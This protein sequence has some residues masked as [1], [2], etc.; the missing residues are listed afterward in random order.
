MQKITKASFRDC[1]ISD[2]K[3]FHNSKCLMPI[4]IGQKVHEGDKFLSTI[5]LIN[6]SF[7]SCVILIDDSV[8]RH[9]IKI[10][11]CSDEDTLYNKAIYEG[12]LWLE[13][14]QKIYT[15]LTIPY[16]IIRWDKFLRHPEFRNK[17][18]II[19]NLYNY[20]ENYKKA[21]DNNIEIFLSRY[22]KRLEND[23]DYQYAFSCC[24]DY[25]KEECTGL[26]L[27]IEEECEFEV[28]PSGRNESMFATYELLIKPSHP[29]LLKS[30]ALRFKKYPINR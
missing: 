7:K 5:K 30:V 2:R 25:L 11:D 13:R 8:Q 22:L 21:I 19:D 26:C 1:P 23:I 16:Y 20:N 4:S 17:Y 24:L 18:A 29:N 6:A 15:Q 27:W 12:N 14:N 10:T 9:T 28:Y 3:T